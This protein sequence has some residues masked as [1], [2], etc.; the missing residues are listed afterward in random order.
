MYSAKRRRSSTW[1]SNSDENLELLIESNDE[2]SGSP[3]VFSMTISAGDDAALEDYYR[4]SLISL[5]QINCRLIAKSIIKV[6]EPRKQV[7]HPYNGGKDVSGAPRDPECSKPPWWPRGLRHKEPDHL[8]KT[9][10]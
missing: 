10:K 8:R 2:D 5:Q 6:I 4:R 7:V 9:G 1:G 3:A